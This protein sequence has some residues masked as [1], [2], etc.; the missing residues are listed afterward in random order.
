MRREGERNDT[1]TSNN[2]LSFIMHP[3]TLS[4]FSYLEET[5]LSSQVADEAGQWHAP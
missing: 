1:R 2:F 5:P 4:S 3:P